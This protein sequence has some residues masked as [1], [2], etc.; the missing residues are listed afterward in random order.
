[1]TE[2]HLYIL[3]FGLSFLGTVAVFLTLWLIA[4]RSRNE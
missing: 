1:M 2:D 3:A 4:E